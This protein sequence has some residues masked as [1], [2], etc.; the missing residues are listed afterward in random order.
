MSLDRHNQQNPFASPEVATSANRREHREPVPVFC[1][2]VLVM[3]LVF[4]GL[5]AAAVVLGMSILQSTE[6]DATLARIIELGATEHVAGT[7]IVLLGIPA[8]IFLLQRR[9]LG[10]Y[11]GY[12]KIVAVVGSIIAMGM[13]LARFQQNIRAENS[14]QYVLLAIAVAILAL[15]LALLLAYL[16]AV[17]KLAAT[18]YQ[19]RG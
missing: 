6:N 10:F 2:V 13:Q 8:N 16:L 5:R 3:D 9:K 18:H 1:L 11:L 7:L 14:E 19:Q 12:G 4:C 17:R 15:R